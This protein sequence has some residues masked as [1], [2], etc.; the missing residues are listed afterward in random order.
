MTEK[1]SMFW[2]D[3]IAREASPFNGKHVV[4]DAKTPSGR[5]HVGSLRGVVIH[6]LIHKAVI[7]SGQ[8][9]EY[10]YR[11]DDFDPMDGFPPELPESF[12]KYMGTPLCNIPSHEKGFDS[13]S[14]NYALE[15]QEVFEKLG[16]KPKIVWASQAYSSGRMNELMR[17]ALVNAEKVR[18]INVKI[19]G[20]K[21]QE[22][23]LP[24][25]VVCEKCG[26]IG[27]THVTDFDG[28]TVKYVC[29][30]AKY[31]EGCK[32]EGRVS[33][34][35][36]KAKMT[37]KLEWASQFAL[38]EVTIEGA[39][40]DHYAAGGSRDVANRLS[41]EV[42]H[43]PHPYNFPYEFFL[44]GGKKMST[45]KGVGVSAKQISELVHPSLLRFLLTRFKPRTAIN[46]DPSGDTV[47]RLYDD[48]DKFARVFFGK[49]KSVDPDTPRI[50]ELSA[51]KK[52]HDVFRPSF[53]FISFLVQIPGV[54][55]EKAIELQKGSPLSVEE[56]EI[57]KERMDYARK[58]LEDLAPEEARIK[59]LPVSESKKVFHSLNDEL[60]NALKEFAEAFA[61]GSEV[62]VKS[63]CEKHSVPV[64]EFFSSCYKIT[65]GRD[66]GPKLLPMLQALGKDFVK[67]RFTE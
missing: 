7:D 41:D 57:L 58:W 40:K 22:G 49:D 32:H 4:S 59:L 11:F 31:A 6:D 16:C 44:L 24:I 51:L 14:Q 26:K 45:S 47:P 27:T 48:F 2:A 15:F 23:W 38:Y 18:E 34:F 30:G 35:N 39:G 37:W 3:Q 42:F 9:S 66:K 13:L 8:K 17:T 53:S 62:D 36:G 55:V 46:F 1:E 54:N 33:P 52:E 63:I 61:S 10:V 25:N 65:L 29:A 20:A 56:K 5:I 12:R 64:S 50:F 21:K 60:K 67:E 19:S 43:Y 28:K